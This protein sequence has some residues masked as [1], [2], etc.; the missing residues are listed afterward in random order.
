MPE[1][2]ARPFLYLCFQEE[3]AGTDR[4]LLAD[5]FQPRQTEE[6]FLWEGGRS[7]FKACVARAT[8]HG[9]RYENR[10]SIFYSAVSVS[11]KRVVCGIRF[12]LLEI[13][14]KRHL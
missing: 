14:L 11:K 4:L 5:L 3:G 2:L 8:G 7:K 13:I 10:G 9:F 12:K 1:L 6:A